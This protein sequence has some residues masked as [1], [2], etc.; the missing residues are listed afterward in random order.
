[1]D[2]EN[3]VEGLMN[4]SDSIEYDVGPEV[5]KV[6]QEERM[7]SS[8]SMMTN[9]GELQTAT[10]NT[11]APIPRFIPDEPPSAMGASVGME[12]QPVDTWDGGVGSLHEMLFTPSPRLANDSLAAVVLE[13]YVKEK[14]EKVEKEEDEKEIASLENMLPQDNII[15]RVVDQSRDQ[16][17]ASS[18]GGLMEL[19]AGGRFSGMVPGQGHGMQDNVYM[20]IK[21][22]GQQVATLAVSPK[23]YV[24]DAHTMSAIGNGNAEQGAKVMD[25]A[26]KKIRTK[27]YGT[28]EQ[29]N[30]ID[31]LSSLKPIIERV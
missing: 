18:E 1:M 28:D 5:L 23:E 8:P 14:I 30:Q 22:R 24:V 11:Q 17:A 19:A 20:P 12:E 25:E 9:Q 7:K 3:K 2:E 29:P 27:A 10:R 21:E 31:G 4:L 16:L 13:P 26:V 15:S 6:L